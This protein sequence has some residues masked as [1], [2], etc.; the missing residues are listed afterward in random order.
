MTSAESSYSLLRAI[1]SQNGEHK[2]AEKRPIPVFRYLD[3][4]ST[5]RN[6]NNYPNPNN[7]VIPMLYPSRTSN[8]NSAIDPVSLALPFHS[9]LDSTLVPP[10]PAGVYDTSAISAGPTE[11]VLDLRETE[12]DNFYVGAIL[13]I[14]T[15]YRTIVSYDGTTKI[16]T[17]DSAFAAYPVTIAAGVA[18]LTRKGIPVYSGN[19][20]GVTTD[21]EFAVVGASSLPNIYVNGFVRFLTGAN[22]NL[23]RRIVSYSGDPLNTLVVDSAFPNAVIVGDTLEIDSFSYDNAIPLLYSGDPNTSTNTYYEIELLWMTFP[24]QVLGVG[25]GGEP[26][27]YPA[28]Y[29]QLY[30]DGNMLANQVMYSNNGAASMSALFVTPIADYYGDSKFLTLKDCR[31]RQIVKFIPNQDL[32]FT[33]TLPSGEVVQFADS[34]TLSPNAPNPFLQVHALFSL[35]KIDKL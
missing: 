32:R 14:G 6:R 34:D 10:I 4:D 15:E 30:N 25:Y 17:I 22:A 5:H 3:I 27:K 19:V 11:A 16:A 20:T 33:I 2:S 9:P 28:L 18:Y 31:M 21:Q 23:S 26:D 7:F 35:R 1:A 29:V 8:S 24:K 12:I 13:Q